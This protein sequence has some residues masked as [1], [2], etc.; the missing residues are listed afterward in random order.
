MPQLRRVVDYARC[1][2]SSWRD[3]ATPEQSRT[4][5]LALGISWLN[6][7]HIATWLIGPATITEDCSFVE[8]LTSC[9][10]IPL[11]FVSHWWGEC[12]VD[13][14]QCLELHLQ[15]R[16]VGEDPAYWVC[17]YANRQHSLTDEVADNPK[18][19]S[20]YKALQLSS[21]L[22]L[23][24]D[25]ATGSSGPATPFSRIWCG[26]EQSVALDDG[27]REE[28]MLLDI[29]TCTGKE[30]QLITDGV[31]MVDQYHV[32][33]TKAK[34]LR[35]SKFPLEIFRVGLST[36]LEKGQA[37]NEEDRIRI[38]NCL[39][40]RGLDQTPP[41]DEHENYT[42][43]NNKLRAIFA[44]AVWR[45][46]V[47]KRV[48]AD[49]QLPQR[50]AANTGM[51]LITLD[52]T[53]CDS[54]DY[55]NLLE[56]T[57]A[58]PV[59]LEQCN[60]ML[61]ECRHVGDGNSAI[62]ARGIPASLKRFSVNFNECTRLGNAGLAA[63]AACLPVGLRSLSLSFWGC[64]RIGDPGVVALA[65]A[66]PVGLHDLTLNFHGTGLTDA[67]VAAIAGC[68]PH[69]LHDLKL[70]FSVCEEVGDSGAASLALCLPYT[71]KE[72]EF[73]FEGCSLLTD[74]GIAS[75]M[76]RFMQDHIQ[77]TLKL[78]GSGVSEEVRR[79]SADWEALCKWYVLDALWVAEAND[80]RVEAADVAEA[81][82]D[83]APPEEVMKN[84]GPRIH[85]RDETVSRGLRLLSELK[86]HA[87]APF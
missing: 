45:L 29:A 19:S 24:L 58:L 18:E 76:Q 87:T 68:L 69:Q 39:A 43:V 17:A 55:A 71:L 59:G 15:I 32:F 22:L 85:K 70:Y 84:D 5:G 49:L 35:E 8:L 64:S 56:L 65:A 9:E 46:S 30:A 72:L 33:P 78:A 57:H 74:A 54:L 11:W 83:D 13:F 34:V 44:V 23:V 40:D 42:R 48:V 75:L 53:G 36:C 20:F 2:C 7:Y 61:R 47:E 14:M 63:F 38:L 26:F 77:V 21:G 86:R 66:L 62:L 41:L 4:S 73:R 82:Q 28:P 1:N 25:A 27:D 6:L 67:G 81:V 60:L 52:F 79:S 3:I 12:L 10:Q 80:T 37:S 50:L 16:R 31:A 51:K